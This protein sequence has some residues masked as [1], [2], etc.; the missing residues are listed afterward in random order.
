MAAELRAFDPNGD[1]LLIL[2]EEYEV[3]ANS[4]C[5]NHGRLDVDEDA[6]DTVDGQGGAEDHEMGGADETENGGETRVA[7]GSNVN[8]SESGQPSKSPKSVKTAWK[9]IH[10]LVSSKHLALASSVFAAML[11]GGFKESIDLSSDGKI[12]VPLPD[13]DVGAFTILLD[14]IHGRNR[15]VPRK[16]ELSMLTKLSILVDKYALHEVAE[17]FS[18]IW[19]E[20]LSK[21]LLGASWKEEH[22]WLCISWV[23]R[24]NR[25]FNNITWL[26][27]WMRDVDIEDDVAMGLPIPNRVIGEN[28]G[29][30]TPELVLRKY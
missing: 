14:I 23:F 28:T 6:N 8:L 11:Y 16:M 18:N 26:V 29:D 9:D 17:V 4:Q 24:D 27:M 21:G 3:E 10:L 15:R 20:D 22:D 13:D 1:L 30:R 25:L 12:S 5:A 2:Q 7:P 19:I